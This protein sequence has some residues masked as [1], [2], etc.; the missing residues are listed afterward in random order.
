MTGSLSQ[1]YIQVVFAVKGSEALLHKAWRQE[2][3]KNMPGI[4]KEK[5]QKS[6]IINSEADHVHHHKKR[7]FREEC[8]SFLDKHQIPYEERFLFDQL[9]QH[10]PAGGLN[11]QAA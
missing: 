7:T 4:I 11:Y 8:I 10:E 6:I 5:R 2:I 9:E 3:F 1:I